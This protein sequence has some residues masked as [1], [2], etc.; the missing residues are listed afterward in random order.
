MEQIR[1]RTKEEGEKQT[2]KG[3]KTDEKEEEDQRRKRRRRKEK[4]LN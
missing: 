4:D 2:I 1:T 3:V